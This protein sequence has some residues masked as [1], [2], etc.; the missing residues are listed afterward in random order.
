MLH[1]GVYLERFKVAYRGDAD[2]DERAMRDCLDALPKPLHP[3]L[4]GL[5]KDFI[6]ELA[7]P[8]QAD[9]PALCAWLLKRGRS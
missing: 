2:A 1:E 6:G 3:R 8:A 7:E 5:I 4:P 9:V